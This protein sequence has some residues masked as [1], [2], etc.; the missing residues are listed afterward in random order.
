MLITLLNKTINPISFNK[1]HICSEKNHQFYLII[2]I[3]YNY[4]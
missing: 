3:N 1:T 2:I 4:K